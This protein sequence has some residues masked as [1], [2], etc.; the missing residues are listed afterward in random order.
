MVFWGSDLL[1]DRDRSPTCS[2]CYRGNASICSAQSNNDRMC[3][4][5][6]SLH[7]NKH[8]VLVVFVIVGMPV[9]TI[10]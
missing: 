3:K 8:V 2:R 6:D 1:S 7:E 10:N 5:Y 4:R 9:E